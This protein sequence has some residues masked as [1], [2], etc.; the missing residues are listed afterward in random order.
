MYLELCAPHPKSD[1]ISLYRTILGVTETIKGINFKFHKYFYSSLNLEKLDPMCFYTQK[2]NLFIQQ[3]CLIVFKEEFG[4]MINI[5][6]EGTKYFL[7]LTKCFVK[8][9]KLFIW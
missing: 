2:K 9:T 1:R 7:G 4:W 6:V 5:F 3:N 8:S